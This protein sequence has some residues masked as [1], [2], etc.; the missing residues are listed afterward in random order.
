M[1]SH[2]ARPY[3]ARL[4]IRTPHAGRAGGDLSDLFST[5]DADDEPHGGA[6]GGAP[7]RATLRLV[8]PASDLL[9]RLLDEHGAALR[10]DAAAGLF[11]RCLWL[12]PS[13]PAVRWVRR[14]LD[15]RCGAVLGLRV[16]TFDDFAAA[17]LRAAGRRDGVLGRAARRRVLRRAID[18]LANG[19]AIRR[20]ARIAETSGFLAAAER[21]LDAAA[22]DAADDDFTRVRA[23]YRELLADGRSV[24]PEGR[25]RDAAERLEAGDDAAPTHRLTVAGFDEFTPAQWRL[26][27]GFLAGS[28]E[29]V[30]AGFVTGDRDDPR[31]LF[32]TP[33]DTAERFADLLDRRGFTVQRQ[34]GTAAADGPLPTLARG[35]FRPD[36]EPTDADAA[37]VTVI[38]AG[39]ARRELETIAVRVKGLLADGVE[40]ADVVLTTPDAPG[41][42]A[43]VRE[44]F[45]A[46]GVPV[47][48][49]L[50]V[51][52]SRTGPLRAALRLFE[53]ERDRWDY[54]GVREL[55]RSPF[56]PNLRQVGGVEAERAVTRV[57]RYANVGEDRTDMLRAARRVRDLT[58]K[59]AVHRGPTAAEA[60]AAAES[61]AALDRL[62]ARLRGRLPFSAWCGRVGEVAEELGVL[63][64]PE[65]GGEADGGG[66]PVADGGDAGEA[67]IAAR[68]AFAEALDAATKLTDSDDALTLG[69]FL[70]RFA[71]YADAVTVCVRPAVPGGVRVLDP[72]ELR[73]LRCGHLFFCGA[74]EGAVP[75]LG[76]SPER[77]GSDDEEA[78]PFAA[79]D[80][81]PADG[82]VPDV[83]A[84]VRGEMRLFLAASA[85]PRESLTF[86]YPTL[87]SSGRLLFPS[88]FVTAARGVFAG[89]AV[90]VVAAGALS[91][92][93]PHGEVVTDADL[94]VRAAADVYRDRDAALY[95]R[96]LD[97]PR[98]AA[99]AR[100]GLA[101]NRMLAARFS[102]Q[103]FTE[104]E[105]RITG[106][107]HRKRLRIRYAPTREFSA[108]DLE[109]YARNPFNYFLTRVLQVDRPD[110]PGLA[111]D[112]RLRGSVLHDALAETHREADPSGDDRDAD[113]LVARITQLLRDRLPAGRGD[114]GWQVGLRDSERELL[115]EWAGRYGT[116]AAEYAGAFGAVWDAPPVPRLLEFG[117]GERV[118]DEAHDPTAGRPAAVSFGRS[119]PPDAG[120]PDAGDP[121]AGDPD[122]GDP[123]AG[124]TADRAAA[125]DFPPVRVGGRIDR[126][127]VGTRQGEPVF[128]LIDYKLKSGRSIEPDA[129]DDGRTLQLAVYAAAVGRLGLLG[130]A[131]PWHLGYWSLSGEGYK[132]AVKAGRSAL[133]PGVPVTESLG[134]LD[135]RLDAVLPRLAA[136]IRA[137]LFPINPDV[138][139]YR[140]DVGRVARVGEIRSVDARLGKAYPGL[141]ALLGIGGRDD[142]R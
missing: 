29:T 65:V 20:H 73:G 52:L 41:R 127:D 90:S 85:C 81:N 40:P 54:G 72:G 128:N 121:D 61:L 113:T 130:D 118:P 24:D 112:P 36:H 84:Q 49:E 82:D 10:A 39:T 98:H 132:A 87:D 6:A 58:E 71:E 15:R 21:H 27:D 63:P 44:V 2:P 114:A 13:F 38:A 19:G 104:F 103:Y 74:G 8:E 68:R 115:G 55:L 141:N 30:S 67:G 16:E 86:S 26:L 9:E 88:P 95:A 137:G 1:D 70:S 135:D 37:G 11:G 93:R 31:D 108:G 3:P 111:D 120:D 80:R 94:R 62:A 14:E 4:T 124:D 12:A 78:P 77:R 134:D 79:A 142:E 75:R 99:A 125:D 116:Q 139:T 51:P 126:V 25:D 66:E 100:C 133:E 46:A 48:R 102:Q 138:P 60:A 57:L 119:V 59:Q 76:R 50:S 140:A 45:D 106:S 34:R 17:V 129:L 117:F 22:D 64:V 18:A 7:R 43:E 97:D 83:E 56:A 35:L 136:G 33:R 92:V 123:D 110:P 42:P 5:I 89:D 28:V 47:D 105:G 96:L 53:M 91:P 23:R 107:S 69:R 101:A 32:D 109:M 131:R 122:A